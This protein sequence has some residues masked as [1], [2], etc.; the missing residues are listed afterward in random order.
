MNKYL[1]FVTDDGTQLIPIGQGLYV[2]QTSATALRLYSTESFTHHYQLTTVA[3]TFALVNAV[4]AAL[5]EAS[6]T[7][8]RDTVHPVALP[9]GQTV[10]SIAVT[11]FS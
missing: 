11:V 10:T 6:Q 3:G 1:S 4:N 2:E 5:T 9:T 7:N 8:W